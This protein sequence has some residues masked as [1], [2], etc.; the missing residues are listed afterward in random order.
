MGTARFFC[1]GFVF[2][3]FGWLDLW[4]PGQGPVFRRSKGMERKRIE[5]EIEGLISPVLSRNHVELVDVTY[6]FEGGRWV[7]R[8]FIDKPGGVTVGD[9]A[10][11]SHQIEDLIEMEEVIPLRYF[12]EVSSPGLDR[13]LKREADFQRFCGEMAKV[14]TREAVGG[15]RNFK[16]RILRCEQGVVELEDEEGNRFAFSLDAIERARLAFSGKI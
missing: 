5:S 4:V 2:Y 14:R 15:R 13:V 9:C 12:L 6:R 16:A 10:F 1:M 7:L 11:I 8:V 3:F